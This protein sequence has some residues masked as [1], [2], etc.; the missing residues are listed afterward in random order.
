VTPTWKR[1]ARHWSLRSLDGPPLRRRSLKP[2]PPLGVAR[3]GAVETSA[4]G[5]EAVQR[6]RLHRT[7]EADTA[8]AP[9]VRLGDQ[10]MRPLTG[11]RGH[12]SP[13][14]SK[15]WSRAK[16]T[17]RCGTG[18][19]REEKPAAMGLEGLRILSF[20]DSRSLGGAAEVALLLLLLAISGPCTYPDESPALGLTGN[21]RN[22]ELEQPASAMREL[23]LVVL[24]RGDGAF[25]SCVHELVVDR[26]A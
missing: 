25:D 21:L 19:S 13:G 18:S 17:P 14:A 8:R 15:L 11:G 22:R 9:R 12:G 2:G 23:L 26:L 3:A 16:G 1:T 7:A 6:G 4:L 24:S 5:A 10:M 20:R